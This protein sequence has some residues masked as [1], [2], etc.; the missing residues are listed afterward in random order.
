MVG[1]TSIFGQPRL[2]GSNENIDVANPFFVPQGVLDS[3]IGLLFP[4]VFSR[5]GRLA[6]PALPPHRRIERQQIKW[7]AFGLAFAF[8]TIIVGDFVLP[9]SGVL[10][11]VVA[12]AGF[13]PSRCRLGVAVLRFRLYD[14]DVVVRKTVVA[15]CWRCSSGSSTRPSWRRGACW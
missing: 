1:V 2:T 15:G 5:V 3:A 10:A 14:L 6:L 7:V 4:V 8:V 12:G 13:W 9:G 11:A